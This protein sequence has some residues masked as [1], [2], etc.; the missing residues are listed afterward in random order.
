M[1]H[2]ELCVILTDMLNVTEAGDEVTLEKLNNEY[3]IVARGTYKE[4]KTKLDLDHDVCRTLCISALQY[5]SQH[6]HY[7]KQA[8]ETLTKLN[9]CI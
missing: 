4:P 3:E 5:K 6:A 7:M 2:K 9:A 1:S 8:R